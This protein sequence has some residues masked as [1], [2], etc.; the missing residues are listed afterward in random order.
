M[1]PTDRSISPQMS[2]ITSPYAMIMIGA[3]TTD[4]LTSA[5]CVKKTLR[6]VELMTPK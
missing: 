4:R 3:A 5:A 2:S 1:K 6:P